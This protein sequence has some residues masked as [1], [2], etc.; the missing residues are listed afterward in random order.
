MKQ[1]V[2]HIDVLINNEGV[3]KSTANQNKDGL[4]IRFVVNYLAPC[5]LMKGWRT[6][7]KKA[8]IPL[9]SI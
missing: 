6:C 4:D 7:S 3:L 8:P 5:L 1:Q 9:L 2:D